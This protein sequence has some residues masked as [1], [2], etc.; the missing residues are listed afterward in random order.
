MNLRGGVAKPTTIV[1][2]LGDSVGTQRFFFQI[3]KVG[4][5]EIFHKKT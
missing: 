5:L 1:R 3:S 4:G 2:L